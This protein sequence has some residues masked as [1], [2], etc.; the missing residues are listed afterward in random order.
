MYDENTLPACKTIIIQNELDDDFLT[1]TQCNSNESLL[2]DIDIE[3][4]T[5]SQ[6]MKKPAR[7][8]QR[9]C[10][11][12]NS[13]KTEAPP[14]IKVK[15]F[16]AVKM[17]Q[18]NGGIVTCKPPTHV[19][20]LEGTNNMQRRR[21]FGGT[22]SHDKT[23]LRKSGE[24]ANSDPMKITTAR[25]T[26][27]G[28]TP[29]ST[30]TP[31]KNNLAGKVNV[32]TSCSKNSETSY[33][34][35]PIKTTVVSKS[36]HNSNSANSKTG[37][38]TLTKF[39]NN[40][41]TS[42]ISSR[43]IDDRIN[44]KMTGGQ[45]MNSFAVNNPASHCNSKFRNEINRDSA[46]SSDDLSINPASLLM[47]LSNTSNPL[48]PVEST[49]SQTHVVTSC[50]PS[51]PATSPSSDNLNEKGC[52]RPSSYAHSLKLIDPKSPSKPSATGKSENERTNIKSS[53]QSDDLTSLSW[54]H[55][56]DM[57]GMVPHLSTPPT[58]PAS[59]PLSSQAASLDPKKKNRLSDSNEETQ[60]PDPVDYS[61]D[62]SVKPPYSYAALIGMAMKE[63]GNKMTL[64]AIY[65]WIREHYI[66]YKTADPSWQVSIKITV[67]H[68]STFF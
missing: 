48:S 21:T 32:S 55:S 26:R 34:K 3:Q 57:V 56:L 31:I 6:T 42:D 12:F 10:K 30:A 46:D 44:G 66:F 20:R 1:G 14:V 51:T 28:V 63:N 8:Y 43:V 37:V 24:R 16:Q 25:F 60:R 67:S 47:S 38:I 35:C 5:T 29:S 2:H 4:I 59:P 22:V 65:K 41:K 54:L 58:P 7:T 17:P 53:A 23:F 27:S 39:T 11:V 13:S 49:S 61:K 62:G 64:S 15:A 33:S 45:W 18:K 52:L 40:S 68:S 19:K 9:K 36:S 50:L